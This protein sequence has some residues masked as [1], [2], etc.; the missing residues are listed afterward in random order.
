VDLVEQVVEVALQHGLELV[1]RD[2]RA[3]IGDPALREVVGADL[4]A[5]PTCARRSLAR[6]P[7]ARSCSA[8]SSRARSTFIALFLFLSWLFSS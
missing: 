8:S 6:S 5:A 7:A 3:V 2:A 4:L 1:N